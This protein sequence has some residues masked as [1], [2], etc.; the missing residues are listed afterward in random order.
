MY[1]S[2]LAAILVVLA[3]LSC[4]V[5]LATP[6]PDL[7]SSLANTLTHIGLSV[8]EG[9]TA[10]LAIGGNQRQKQVGRQAADALIVTAAATGL[11]KEI[12]NQSR[13]N[14]PQAQEGFPSG[15]ASLTFAFAR[16]ISDEYKD[17]GKLAY[18]W[19]AGV[20]WS[21]VRREDHSVAQVMAGA[22]LGWWVADRSLGSHGGLLNGLIVKQV[23]L[24]F[25][26]QPTEGRS[27]ASL[28]LWQTSW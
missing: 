16:C 3:G 12:T 1:R 24:A 23:P 21:R 22:A 25:S 5:A 4:P 18:L 14:D 17:W 26:S 8:V 27:V 9:T 7:S 13:P 11:L 20:S 28:R 2:S 6:Q 19:A 10:Y 15:H